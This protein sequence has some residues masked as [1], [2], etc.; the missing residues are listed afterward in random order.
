MSPIQHIAVPDGA[1]I[2][3]YDT[4]PGHYVDC[5]QTY[6][7]QDVDLSNYI[8]AFFQTGLF[9]IERRILGVFAKAP[10]NAAD[11]AR[12]ADGTGDR[13]ALWRVEARREHEILL[14]IN[15][16]RIRT[17]LRAEPGAEGGTV[18]SF[19]SVVI[20]AQVD[21]N[22]NARMG[23]L[24]HGLKAFHLW[25]SRALLWSARRRA[26]RERLAAVQTATTAPKN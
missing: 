23:P 25:Y 24:F 21:A 6:T 8:S 7:E 11:V 13:L 22:G 14:A 4:R 20:P 9:R 26:N 17:W 5:F 1:L 15:P 12:L 18:L 10:S 16:G 3:E 19:G 2:Q